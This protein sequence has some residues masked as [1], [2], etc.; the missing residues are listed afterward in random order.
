MGIGD[1]GR[2]AAGGVARDEIVRELVR[3]PKGSD[4]RSE[5]GEVGERGDP[6]AIDELRRYVCRVLGVDPKVEGES[7]VPFNGVGSSATR[8]W[9]GRASA[10]S[11]APGGTAKRARTTATARTRRT[12]RTKRTKRTERTGRTERTERTEQTKRTERTPTIRSSPRRRSATSR[13]VASDPA[14]SPSNAHPPPGD[15]HLGDGPHGPNTSVSSRS[16]FCSFRANACVFGGRWQYEVTIR[17]AGIMQIGWA[18]VRCPFTQEHGVGDAQD[19]YA[20]DGHRVRK[21]NVACQPYGQPWVPGDVITCCIDLNSD[22]DGGGTVSYLRN[23]ASMGVAFRNVRR[24]QPGLAYFP[25][26]SLSV[27]EAMDLN[28]GSSPMRYPREGHAPLTA[29]ADVAPAWRKSVEAFARLCAFGGVD[30]PAPSNVTYRCE[31]SGTMYR[32]S[33]TPALLTRDDEAMLACATLQAAGPAEGIDEDDAV[34]A[35]APDPRPATR[36]DTN[37]HSR[38][39]TKARRRVRAHDAF[40]ARRFVRRPLPDR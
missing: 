5:K 34:R 28:F 2:D 18:T 33:G 32:Q 23:G 30:D 38:G 31:A 26:V 6:R 21:W 10:P 24:S 20:F 17:T 1:D 9:T 8:A 37:G 13:S 25:A 14:S 35:A 39:G 22:E 7:V 27:N 29:A 36:V 3:E 12:K 40:A 4:G 11:V 19:S 16:N 15:M